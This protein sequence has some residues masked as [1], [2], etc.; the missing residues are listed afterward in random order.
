[1]PCMGAMSVASE[2]GSPWYV[3]LLAV[4]NPLRRDSV[5]ALARE[6]DR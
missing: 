4:G 2:R 6:I 3:G 5:A 1:M